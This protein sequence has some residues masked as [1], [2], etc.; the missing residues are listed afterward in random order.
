MATLTVLGP[1]GADGAAG[2]DVPPPDPPPQ[3]QRNKAP[4]TAA[5]APDKKDARIQVLLQ[6]MWQLF[7]SLGEQVQYQ[8]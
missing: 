2:F 5:P 3:P 8:R 1:L 7:A 4:T 6:Q